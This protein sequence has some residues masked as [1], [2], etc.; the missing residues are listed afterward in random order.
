MQVAIWI[1]AAWF[2]ASIMSLVALYNI[3]F[4]GE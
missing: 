4:L 1:G 3:D 2:A